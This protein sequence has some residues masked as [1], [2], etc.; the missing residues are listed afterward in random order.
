MAGKRRGAGEPHRIPIHVVAK[1]DDIGDR[2]RAL[3]LVRLLRIRRVSDDVRKQLERGTCVLRQHR[4]RP[5][6]ALDAR[7]A[8]DAPA[9]ELRLLGDD[10]GAPTA[11]SLERRPD[12]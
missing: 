1:R 4:D 12:Q 5:A 11:R 3:G 9:E 2:D 7:R 6:K 8:A 10:G